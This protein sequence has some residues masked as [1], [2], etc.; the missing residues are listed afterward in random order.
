MQRAEKIA[1]DLAQIDDFLDGSDGGLAKR[2]QAA[3][4][5]RTD[6]PRLTSALADALAA[7]D[8][9]VTEGARSRRSGCATRR[10]AL[11]FDPRALEDD[12]ARLFELRAMARKHRVQP[13]DLPDLT[14]ELTAKLERLDA[15]E[16]GVA[17]LEKRVAGVRAPIS[18][19]LR[20]PCTGHV[21]P[22]QRGSIGRSR[23]N[24]RRSNS[25]RH[26]SE[27][28][29]SRSI[30]RIGGAAGTDR[31]EFEIATNPGRALR[32]ADPRSPRAANYRASSSRSRSRWPEEG[33]AAT[34]I[35]DETRSWA[36]AAR[37]RARSATG[38]RASPTARSCSSSRTSPQVA[39][40]GTPAPADRKKP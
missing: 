31:V 13:D 15:G 10:L 29:S 20:K 35:F 14:A 7:I 37:W 18:S 1:D 23:A 3:R 9:A 4:S 25:T 22:P 38:W 36:S 34:M 5:A 26:A 11:T 39:A 33:G 12:E 17:A 2:R 19:T 21:A 32:A 40:R 16:G 24:S 28:R 6:R 8:R 30:R 27:P